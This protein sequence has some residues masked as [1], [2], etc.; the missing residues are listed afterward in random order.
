VVVE[1]VGVMATKMY[2]VPQQ[3]LDR[4]KK[5]MQGPED[6]RQ[7]AENDLDTAM[8]DVLN[9]KGLNPYDKIQKYTNLMQ[10][11]LTRVKQGERETNHL[12]LSLP[13]PLTDVEPNDS[14][15]PV[16]PVPSILPS[17]DNMSGE[18]QMPFEDKVMH[19][20]LTHVP[21]RNRKN[22][23]YIMNKIKDSKGIAAWNDSG[24]FIL[25]GSVV[26]GS[27]MQDL[28]KS[29]TAAH[30]VADDRRPPGWRQFLKA[31][32]ILN[33]PLSGVPNHKL[34]QQIQALK[35][36]PSTRYSTPKDAPTTPAP[37][38]SDDANSFTPMNVSGPFPKPDLSA[39]LDF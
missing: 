33:I 16:R 17:G 24:E 28:L 9:R 34:R 23:K 38:E 13:D 2:L 25:Q 39:W 6:I 12:T 3:E 20:L 10:R 36:K 35:Q 32:A 27:H 1:H 19:D 26:R 7:T 31:L 29:T 18:A 8:K 11:Y 22:V 37:Y 30:K 21:L 5:Q 15:A 14:H 4:L